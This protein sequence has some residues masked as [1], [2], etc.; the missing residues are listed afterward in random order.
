M[1]H[2]SK[3][4]GYSSLSL[5]E[6]FEPSLQCAVDF[7]SVKGAS[8]WLTALPLQEY[9]FALHKSAFQD[10]LALHYGWSPLRAPSLCA[11][12]SSFSVEHVLSC[13][14]PSLRRND[15]RDLTTSLLTEVCPQVIV[16]PEL[17]PVSNPDEYS[18]S[19]L[20]TQD[21]ACLDV[22]MNGFLGGQSEKCF[23]DV[24][25][26]NPYAASNKCSSL[27]AA[28]KKHEN[29]K[30]RAYGQRIQE[31]ERTLFS[32]LVLSATGGR[33]HEATIFYK[34]LASLLS[35]KWGDSYSVTLGWL[36]CCLSFSMLCS[37]IACIRGA[38]S[39][40]GHFDRTP[41][42][43]DLVWGR[44]TFNVMIYCLSLK[45]CLLY[46]CVVLYFVSRK[47]KDISR[48]CPFI[49]T[50]RNQNVLAADP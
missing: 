43:I 29:I 34:R 12:G 24:R 16:E 31:V 18:L 17:Q 21:D 3:A 50:K 32:P 7:A 38:W 37:A 6:N 13:G 47:K 30:W 22:A 11:C 49:I 40:T 10:A 42:P 46:L 23:V 26:F 15:I 45:F 20:N 9:G 25:V 1:I 2:K 14:L 27:S 4:E 41:P 28:Y 36:R 19:T 5:R 48:I 44:V 35:N 33:A 8:S 39:S